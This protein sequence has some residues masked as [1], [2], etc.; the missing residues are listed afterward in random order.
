MSSTS[1]RPAELDVLCIGRS[2]IDL[3]AHEVGVPITRVKS[4]DAYVGKD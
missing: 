1:V 3:Y 2:C 4:F